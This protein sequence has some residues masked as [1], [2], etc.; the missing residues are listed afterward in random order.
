MLLKK[1]SKSE[2]TSLKESKDGLYAMY[3]KSF[4]K[5]IVLTPYSDKIK[6]KGNQIESLN[7]NSTEGEFFNY[8]AF[9][10]SLKNDTQ[11]FI[12]NNGETLLI[13]KG[14]QELNTIK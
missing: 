2:L 4:E 13:I 11:Y 9:N 7:I 10:L 12:I 1:Y 6:A 5:G 14:I 3:I 8:L